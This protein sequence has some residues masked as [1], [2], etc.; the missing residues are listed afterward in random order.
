MASHTCKTKKNAQM[1]ASRLRK[2]GLNTSV[3][4]KKS[5]WGVS[6]TR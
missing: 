3:Y 2:K 4:K 6:S 5:G 1:M